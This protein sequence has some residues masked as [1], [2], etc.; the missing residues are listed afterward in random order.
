ML[1]AYSVHHRPVAESSALCHVH[2]ASVS[3]YALHANSGVMTERYV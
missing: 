2:K 1:N 3:V